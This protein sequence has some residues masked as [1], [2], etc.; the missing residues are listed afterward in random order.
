MWKQ[1]ITTWKL[2]FFFCVT[3]PLQGAMNGRGDGLGWVGRREWWRRRRRRW[4][5]RRKRNCS[6]ARNDNRI[7]ATITLRCR[8]HDLFHICRIT[9]RV[10]AV[11][12]GLVD[13]E[14]RWSGRFERNLTTLQLCTRFYSV[15]C[16]GDGAEKNWHYRVVV[17][18][19]SDIDEINRSESAWGYFVPLPSAGFTHRVIWFFN[20]NRALILHASIDL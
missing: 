2:W 18:C 16:Q 11:I 19:S 12:M 8:D 3:T 9:T 17:I 15:V 7:S 20:L 13:D 14:E 5:R 6:P 1:P 10:W 4:W